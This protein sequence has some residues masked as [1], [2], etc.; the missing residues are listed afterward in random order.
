M[1]EE[2]NRVLTD[3]IADHLFVHCPDAVENLLREGIDGERVSFAGNT[4]IDSLLTMEPRIRAAEVASR[5]GLT[6]RTYLLVTLHRPALV[7]GPL[8]SEA[9]AQLRALSHQL[10]VVFPVHPRTRIALGKLELGPRVHLLNPLSYVE[11]ASLQS[12]ARAVLTD[13]GGIQEET[14]FLGVPCFT[15]RENTERPITI[16]QGTNTLLGL[17]PARIADIV[18]ALEAS[19]PPV[20]EPPARWDGRAAERIADAIMRD[21]SEIF[22][23]RRAKLE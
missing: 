18:P 17:D 11:F 20:V 9:V 19:R 5:L 23:E 7:D 3:H 13:S 14:T 6:P 4:M 1:P 2:L 22:S 15:L 16:T 10:P 8:L 21:A 12:D